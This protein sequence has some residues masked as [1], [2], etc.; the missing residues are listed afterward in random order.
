MSVGKVDSAV[1]GYL[2]RIVFLRDDG[3]DRCFEMSVSD[4]VGTNRFDGS[5]V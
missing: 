4:L 1:L 2:E 5:D 3:G